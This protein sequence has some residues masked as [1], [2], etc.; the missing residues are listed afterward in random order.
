MSH[1]PPLPLNPR[2]EFEQLQGT[3][4]RLRFL[5]RYATLAPSSHNTQPWLWRI[6]GD[7]VELR[8]DTT[9]QMPALDP[10]GRELILSC[11]AGLH[12]L[13]LAIRAMGYGAVVQPFPD[14]ENSDLL[15]RVRLGSHRPATTNDERLFG[16][17]AKR[18]THRGEFEARSLPSTLLLELQNVAQIWGAELHFAQGEDQKRQIASLIEHGDIVQQSDRAIRRD[19]TDW[20][21]PTGGR[22]DGIPTRALGVSDWLSH[23]APMGQLLWD[24]GDS[25]ADKDRDLA[26]HAPALAILSARADGPRAW[27]ESGQALSAVLLDARAH[28][29]WASFFSQP[30]QVD[31]AWSALRHLVGKEFF[32]QLVFRLGYAAPV[33]ATPRRPVDEVA[34]VVPTQE[35]D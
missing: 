6:E 16:F 5:L 31:K 17:I 30:I 21:A 10:Q 32:P 26:S 19:M 11:G 8:A 9:R 18:H 12:H 20:I 1:T 29:V 35:W 2:K 28:D 4:E 14:G 13:I 24:R 34:T 15:A 22:R 7:E 25:I 33:P 23:L 3:N 27:L